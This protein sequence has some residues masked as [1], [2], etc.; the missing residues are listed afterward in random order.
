[1]KF[2][3][4]RGAGARVGRGHGLGDLVEIEDTGIG[5]SAEHLPLVFDAFWQVDQARRGHA[6]RGWLT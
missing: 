2:T 3:D 4:R 5:I 1:V 6:G